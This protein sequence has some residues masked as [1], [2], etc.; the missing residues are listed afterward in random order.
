MKDVTAPTQAEPEASLPADAGEPAAPRLPA[1]ESEFRRALWT[2]A[3]ELIVDLGYTYREHFITGQKMRDGAKWLE[4]PRVIFP[5]VASAGTATLALFG[6][7]QLAIV[8]G[9]AGALAIALEKHFD[10]IGRANAHTDKGDRLLSVSKDL[11]FFR[12]VKLR[13]PMTSAELEHELAQLRKRADDLR[14][15]EPRQVPPYAY[16]DARRQIADGQSEYA[17]D[18][19]WQDPPDDL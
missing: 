18:P 12:N 8:F 4:I 1:N 2:S 14:M 3:S 10:P 13:G 19:L 11:R 5:V 15:L 6:L 17:G 9:F 16:P 7:N